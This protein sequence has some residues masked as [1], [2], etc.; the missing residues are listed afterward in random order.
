M[1]INPTHMYGR[2]DVVS[3][4]K[5]VVVGIRIVLFDEKRLDLDILYNADVELFYSNSP[6]WRK[7]L[8]QKMQ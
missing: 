8:V 7:I 2:W 5:N 6:S 1:V 4:W 3:P